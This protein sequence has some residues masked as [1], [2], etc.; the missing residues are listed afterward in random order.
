MTLPF[1]E[2]A[3][4]FLQE[5][6]ACMYST[7]RLSEAGVSEDMA[8]AYAERGAA[9]SLAARVLAGIESSFPSYPFRFD[10]P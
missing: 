6:S 2:T 9:L 5:E 1:L 8:I 4:R 3:V 7:A 10:A